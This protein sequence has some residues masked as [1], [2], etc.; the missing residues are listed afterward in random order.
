VIEALWRGVPCVC[1]DLPVLRE[2]TGAG[3]CV[4]PRVNDLADWCARLRPLLGEKFLAERLAREALARPL[5]TWA[6]AGEMLRA[7]LR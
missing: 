1:S 4:M 6:E 7:E 5:P 2:L 3:G